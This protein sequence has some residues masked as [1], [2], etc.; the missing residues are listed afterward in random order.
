MDLSL[1]DAHE[2]TLLTAQQVASMW[3]MDPSNVYKLIRSK[4]IPSVKIGRSVRVR[5]TDALRFIEAQT[6]PAGTPA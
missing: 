6:N 2:L 3:N 4:K 5:H 1:T